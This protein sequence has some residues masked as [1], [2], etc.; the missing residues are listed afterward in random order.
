MKFHSQLFSYPVNRQ[1]DRHTNTGQHGTR[2][3]AM[4]EVK[5]EVDQCQSSACVRTRLLIL[6]SQS[7]KE[8]IHRREGN[9]R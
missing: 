9:R 7:M 4:A 2:Q 5:T 1:T 8:I 3:A 6:L